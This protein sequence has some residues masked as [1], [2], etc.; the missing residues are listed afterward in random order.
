[1]T[2]N[3]PKFYVIRDCKVWGKFWHCNC[4]VVCN[5]VLYWSAKYRE[6]IVSRQSKPIRGVLIWCT[7]SLLTHEVTIPS[8]KRQDHNFGV[9]MMAFIALYVHHPLQY[10]VDIYD[11]WL[12]LQTHLSSKITLLMTQMW[13]IACRRCSNYIFILNLTPDF[14]RLGQNNWKTRRETFMFWNLVRI[15]LDISR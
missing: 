2:D 7:T 11:N 14:N 1:M 13:S 3:P 10:S 8:L 6:P 9:M 12:C 15:I 5:I 4:C